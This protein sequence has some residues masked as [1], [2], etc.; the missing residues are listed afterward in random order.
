MDPVTGAL[1][2]SAVAWGSILAARHVPLERAFGARGLRI[3]AALALGF[4]GISLLGVPVAR[5][6][7]AAWLLAA[8]AVAGC[9]HLITGSR[10]VS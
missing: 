10:P 3:L 8:V 2:A 6:G 4:L 9:R 5:W 1:L 7:V